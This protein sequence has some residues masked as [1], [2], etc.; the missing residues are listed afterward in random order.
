MKMPTAPRNPTHEMKSFSRTEKRN[1]ARQRNTAAGRAISIRANATS[2]RR[3]QRLRQ[4]ARPG[5]QAEHHEHDDLCKPSRGIEKNH[6]GVVRARGAVPDDEA[7]DIGRQE[8]GCVQRLG[9]R[10]H[11][12]RRDRHE[13]R[14]QALRQIEAIEHPDHRAAAGIADDTADDRLPCQESR[15]ELQ[16]VLLAEQQNL[17][18]HDGE[19]D[20]ERVVG[21]GFD[22]EGRAHPRSQPQP[23]RVQQEEH[24]GRVGGGHGRAH[25]QPFGPAQ[26]EGVARRP[27]RSARP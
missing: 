6:D 13:W 22:F 10:E 9:E 16:P 1:G 25:Q 21:A 12:Q 5:E 23:A 7:G 27:A 17:H 4:T 24:G 2:E 3:Q 15:C 8:A 11:D 18:Q 20:G 26:P 14:M 19:E